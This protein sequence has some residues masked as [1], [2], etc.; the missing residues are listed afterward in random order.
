MGCPDPIT[1]GVL[2]KR[3]DGERAKEALA[4][5]GIL[6]G[7]K[8]VARIGKKLI[9]P[10]TET[11]IDLTTR[12]E[13]EGAKLVH[14]GFKERERTPSS[15]AEVLGEFLSEDEVAAF[16][17]SYD[18]VGDIAV[19]EIPE[20]L[21]DRLT[22]IGEALLRWLPARTV[23]MKSSPTAGRKR[24][25]GLD[26]IAG[27]PSLETTHRENGLEFRL[28]LSKVFFNPRLSGERARVA[29]RCSASRMVID[30]FAG[31]GSFSIT[32]HR[33]MSDGEGRVF[34]V[35]LNRDAHRYLLFNARLNRAWGVEG[36]L[37]DSRRLAPEISS[38]H[39]P[40]DSVVMN[41]PGSSHEFLPAAVASVKEGGMIHYYR[42]TDKDN[43]E[44]TIRRELRE[45]GDFRVELIREVESYSPSRSIYVADARL[46]GRSEN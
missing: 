45:V 32:I 9:F 35:D 2:V 26:V 18:L 8:R 20:E 43:H 23:A 27:E 15:L 3:Q 17:T 12:P 25:R 33:A 19:V 1:N 31:V 39:G 36:L 28:D 30:M 4:S 5:L 6:D 46:M 11:P 10:L 24:L 7:S 42:L 13:L 21:R 22:E 29:S 37:G 41:L 34:A 38:R 40:A 14:H 44:G 16:G